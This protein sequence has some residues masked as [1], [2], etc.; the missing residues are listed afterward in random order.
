MSVHVF[1]FCF[2]RIDGGER[3]HPTC[4]VGEV[5]VAHAHG[6]KVHQHRQQKGEVR[7]VCLWL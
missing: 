5:D 2:A 6:V 3:I 7:L 1:S 4:L